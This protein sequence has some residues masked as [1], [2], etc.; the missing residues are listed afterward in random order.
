M[1]EA[2]PLAIIDG[3]QYDVSKNGE[4][5]EINLITKQVGRGHLKIECWTEPISHEDHFTWRYRISVLGGGLTERKGEFDFEAPL[6]GYRLT[7][8]FGM[9]ATDEKWT[10]R[11][12]KEY[13]LKLSDGNYARVNIQFHPETG[14]DWN[15]IVLKSYLNPQGSRNLEFDPA[16]KIKPK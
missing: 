11:I 2:E 15:F 1:G 3:R 9:N 4:P 8:E 13:F 10:S 7:D 14:D 16:K 6:E 5:I 12:G